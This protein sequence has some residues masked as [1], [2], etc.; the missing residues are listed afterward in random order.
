M[1]IL[2]TGIAQLKCASTLKTLKTLKTYV[3]VFSIVLLGELL[4]QHGFGSHAIAVVG[5]NPPNIGDLTPW[6]GEILI[7]QDGSDGSD[8]M[9]T[10]PGETGFEGDSGEDGGFGGCGGNGAN[11]GVK[12][13]RGGRHERVWWR[14]R[15]AERFSG[16][17]GSTR[18]GCSGVN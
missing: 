5:S 3:L 13:G 16:F 7:G 14:P 18:V 12:G 15:A 4:S 6:D 8:G 9:N 17:R 1:F 11:G 10:L 2:L